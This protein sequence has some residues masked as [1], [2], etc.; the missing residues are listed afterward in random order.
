M[1]GESV[2]DHDARM[3]WAA[4]CMAYFGFLR[5]GEMTVYEDGGYDKS[6]HLGVDDASID[7]PSSPSVVRVRIKQSKT[8]PFRQGVDLFLGRTHTDLAI[9]GY[10]VVRGA[11]P[12]FRFADGRPLT[13]SRFVSLRRGDRQRKLLRA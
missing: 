2:V 10:L 6:V 4:C 7:S 1:L 11:G 3:V 8:D 9:L 13:R 12:L 5:A